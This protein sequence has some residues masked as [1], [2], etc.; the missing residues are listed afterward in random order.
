MFPSSTRVLVVEDAESMRR[1]VVEV[2]RKL[3]LSQ[4]VEAADGAD[5]WAQLAVAQERGA[6]IELIISDL[7]MPFMRGTDLLKKVRATPAF[8]KI[9]FVMLTSHKERDLVVEAARHG[10]D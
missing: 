4:V 1:L 2:L 10:V 5:G 9:P 8:A 6:P 3:S 7:E